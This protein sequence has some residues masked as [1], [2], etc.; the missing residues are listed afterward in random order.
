MKKRRLV[1]NE[2]KDLADIAVKKEEID[3]AAF[4]FALGA[5]SALKW[6][7]CNEGIF[8][9]SKQLSGDIH[10]SKFDFHYEMQ[11][12]KEKHNG[13]APR[14]PLMNRCDN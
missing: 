2:M 8:S 6:V 5:Y 9:P 10:R 3:G 12:H 14:K 11:L 4:L 13:A 1:S 7:L